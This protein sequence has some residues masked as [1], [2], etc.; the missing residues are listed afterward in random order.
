VITAT[1]PDLEPPWPSHAGE[2]RLLV[3]L[4]RSSRLVLLFCETGTDPTSFLR[5]TLMPLLG[6]RDAD[7]FTPETA[8]DTGV[9]AP[10]PDRRK[11]Q[12]GPP[13]MPT[14]R[15]FV[16][17]FDAWDGDPLP[18]LVARIH[19]VANTC[20]AERSA[21]WQRLSDTL[22]ALCNRLDARFIILFDRFE[23]FLRAAPDHA[24][25]AQFISEWV[26][27][28]QRTQLPVSFLMALDD[29]AQPLLSGLRSRVAG[30]DDFSLKL[31]R[32]AAASP[33]PGSAPAPPSRATGAVD[34]PPVLTEAVTECDLAA[35]AGTLPARPAGR[36]PKV[37]RPAPPRSEVKTEDVYALIEST[38][39]RTVTEIPDDPFPDDEPVPQPEPPTA[40]RPAPMDVAVASAAAPSGR[41]RGVF[42]RIGRLLHGRKRL[43]R[44]A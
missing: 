39:S 17:H 2:A 26:E 30:F 40:Q 14:A 21:S 24:G 44:D 41:W 36:P 34:G 20:E 42:A 7:R 1:S 9:V 31:R 6:R 18:A 12:A 37:K 8:P 28:V 4:L 16:V 11:R 10:L 23:E 13:P 38:L 5:S 29:N 33:T 15:E 35:T 22:E 43:G 3:E 19:Q 27:V 32:P 25:R